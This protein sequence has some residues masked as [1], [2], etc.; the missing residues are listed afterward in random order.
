LF[1]D[2]TLIEEVEGAFPPEGRAAIPVP[3]W[4]RWSKKG[5]RGSN[6]QTFFNDDANSENQE[7]GDM[8]KGQSRF[9]I[10]LAC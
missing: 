9:H 3:P 10:Q 8:S 4:W 7:C 6:E 5:T 2:R 1:I